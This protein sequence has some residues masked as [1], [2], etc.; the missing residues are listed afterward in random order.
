M[1]N[2]RIA[3]DADQVKKACDAIGLLSLG[4]KELVFWIVSADI[5]Q[6]QARANYENKN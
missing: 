2:K 1:E 6:S 5:E 3:Q 4:D